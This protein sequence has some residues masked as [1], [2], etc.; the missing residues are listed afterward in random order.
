[1]HNQE[2]ILHILHSIL[3]YIKLPRDATFILCR[4]KIRLYSLS[5]RNIP[6]YVITIR[7]KKYWNCSRWTSFLKASPCFQISADV[8][9]YKPRILFI[10]D[11]MHN[12]L[13]L[14]VNVLWTIG[15]H[16]NC[17]KQNTVQ[18]LFLYMNTIGFS[19]V[20]NCTHNFS[21]YSASLKSNANAISS[22]S[23]VLWASTSCFLLCQLIALPASMNM[24]APIDF[25]YN[26]SCPQSETLE[27]KSL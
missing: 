19:Q 18:V 10:L 20:A 17:C 14:D 6:I 9:L 3:L 16:G 1:M 12:N 4:S 25:Q 27:P 15:N 26:L 22:V 21:N 2:C 7:W 13:V 5:S 11:G 24:Y 8:S 23:T